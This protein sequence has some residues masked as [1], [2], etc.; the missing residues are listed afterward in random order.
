MYSLRQGKKIVLTVEVVF[1][2][3]T[4]DKSHCC[5]INGNE[6]LQ[7]Q[8][9]DKKDVVDPKNIYLD[10]DPE[11]SPAWIRIRN[12]PQFRSGPRNLPQPGSAARNIKTSFTQL[13]YSY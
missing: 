6:W 2:T 10:P 9:E 3:V 11:F 5:K 1:F 8:R 4:Q 7:Q 13:H 12:V